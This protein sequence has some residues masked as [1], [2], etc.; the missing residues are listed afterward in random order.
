MK[1]TGNDGQVKTPSEPIELPVHH[2]ITASAIDAE[3]NHCSHHQHAC[4]T[5][6]DRCRQDLSRRFETI[7]TRDDQNSS[8]QSKQGRNHRQSRQSLNPTKPVRGNPRTKE[9]NLR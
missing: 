7:T 6:Q 5:V 2:P 1:N 8:N 4:D 3:E 9:T